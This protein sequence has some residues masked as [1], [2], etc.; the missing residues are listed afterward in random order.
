[1]NNIISS[2]KQVFPVGKCTLWA[3]YTSVYYAH[4]HFPPF[5]ANGVSLIV[6]FHVTKHQADLE[7]SITLDV[8]LSMLLYRRDHTLSYFI[9]KSPYAQYFLPVPWHHNVNSCRQKFFL[10]RGKGISAN[11]LLFPITKANYIG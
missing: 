3:K 9:T 2:R 1:M 5:F 7:K 10:E 11:N 8:H 6:S 4:K